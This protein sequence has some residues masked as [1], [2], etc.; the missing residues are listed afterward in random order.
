MT[1][2]TQVRMTLDVEPQSTPAGAVGRSGRPA[3]GMWSLATDAAPIN[4]GSY[5]AVPTDT[6]AHQMSLLATME[7]RPGRWFSTLPRRVGAAR[8][9]IA[10]FLGVP[11]ERTALVPNAS[12]GVSVVLQSLD[13]AP[14]AEI[15]VTDH[16]YGAVRMAADRAVARVGG[17]VQI[18]RI[19]LEA[20]DDEVIDALVAEL[21]DRTA[22]VIVDQ[23]TSA[24]ARTLPV[25]GLSVRLR[26][27]GVPLLVDAAHAP[28]MLD[29]PTTGI[30]A[31]YWVGNLHKWA[32]TP[33]GT[34]AL[35]VSARVAH[36]QFPLIDS[37]GAPDPFP[38]RFDMQGTIDATAYL[39]APHALDLI[40]EEFGWS[41]TRRYATDLVSF[42]QQVVADALES[43]TGESARPA[44]SGAA[45]TMRLVEFPAGLVTDQEDAHALSRVLARLGFET[46]VTSWNDRGFLRLSA[47]VYNAPD[48]YTR[49][50]EMAV[51]AV[52]ALHRSRRSDPAPLD[53]VAARTLHDIPARSSE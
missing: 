41:W 38:E 29:L 21:S 4:H 9:R 53:D 24:T 50:A 3:R 13:L 33:R 32:C 27:H 40:E 30:D 12:A 45:P 2:E 23:I 22:L 8:V 14:G 7:A 47:H 52:V 48:D 25:A 20:S 44:I 34:A 43:A 37:W 1:L 10:D 16:I 19:P 28:G 49:F 15:L 5:G 36:D 39:A 42:G 31:D 51:P 6:S 26:A 17:R 46:A 35:V 11:H 18:A